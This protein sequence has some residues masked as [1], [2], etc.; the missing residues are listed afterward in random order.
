MKLYLLPLLLLLLP[1]TCVRAQSTVKDTL[2]KKRVLETAELQILTSDFHTSDYDLSKFV[3][4][5]YS[6]G[7]GNKF[8]NSIIFPKFNPY[9]EAKIN[10]LK[11]LLIEDWSD[12]HQGWKRVEW[13]IK[14]RIEM[15]GRKLRRIEQYFFDG[16]P[17]LYR[18]RATRIGTQEAT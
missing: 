12:W 9:F 14:L 5:Q 3:A 4:N 16:T 10:L 7:V 2:Y 18:V 11:I 1:C 6:L 13:E 17:L 8:D 15:H